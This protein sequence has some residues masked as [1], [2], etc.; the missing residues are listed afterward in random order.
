[1]T[2]SYVARY[3][4]IMPRKNPENRSQRTRRDALL[5]AVDNSRRKLDRGAEVQYLE[6][7]YR[8]FYA[9]TTSSEEKCFYR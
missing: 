4:L 8:S 5:H 6:N 7:K 2:E 9:L 3:V 1:M